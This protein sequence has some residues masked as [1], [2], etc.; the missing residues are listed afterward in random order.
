MSAGQGLEEQEGADLVHVDTWVFDLDN[1]LYPADGPFMASID[2]RITAFAMH[3]TG[4]EHDAAR[5]LQ[6]RYWREH[7][8]TLAGLMAHHA[9]DP[10]AYLA[11]VHDVPLEVLA[12]DPRLN[13]ALARLPGRRL[14]F[15][16]GPAR[17]AERV[18]ARLELEAL[19]EGVFHL[20][21]AGLTPKPSP[22]AFERLMARHAVDPRATA[23][24][25]DTAGNLAPAHALGMTTVWLGAPAPGAE[26]PGFVDHHTAALAPFLEAARVA[27]PRV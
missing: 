19:F 8:T 3:A 22:L 6:K 20:E 25:E 21:A 14:V 11:E 7:G 13:A 15:T 24:F 27:T 23:F 26:V 10:H 1:T 16:N 5:D 17:H 4:L 18:L 9:V 2:A 12:P